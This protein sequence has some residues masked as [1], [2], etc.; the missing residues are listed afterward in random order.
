M[1]IGYRFYVGEKSS[2]AIGEEMRSFQSGLSIPY[3][4]LDAGH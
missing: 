3:L 4:K 1:L 2:T